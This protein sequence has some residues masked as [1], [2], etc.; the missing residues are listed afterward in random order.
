MQE[1]YHIRDLVGL[2][3]LSWYHFHLNANCNC[4][5]FEINRVRIAI[6]QEKERF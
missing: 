2:F 5:M 1:L 4:K 6:S 3:K